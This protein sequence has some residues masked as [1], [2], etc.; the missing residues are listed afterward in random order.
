M[1]GFLFALFLGVIV[2]WLGIGF[3]VRWLIRKVLG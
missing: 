2:S 3:A 1:I